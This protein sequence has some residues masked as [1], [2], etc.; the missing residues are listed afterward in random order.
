MQH[1]NHLDDFIVLNY[2]CH[3]HIITIR[4]EDVVWSLYTLIVVRHMFAYSHFSVTKATWVFATAAVDR[5]QTHL[6]ICNIPN[7]LDD[8]VFD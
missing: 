5:S 3:M 1:S 4:N 7:H 2:R 8:H 6:V